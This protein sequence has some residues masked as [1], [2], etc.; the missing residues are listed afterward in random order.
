MLGHSAHHALQ[1]SVAAIGAPPARVHDLRHTFA[2][3]QLLVGTPM[4]EVSRMLGHVSVAFTLQVYAHIVP[5][6]QSRA[7]EAAANIIEE[8]MRLAEL[9]GVANA[10]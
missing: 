2:S 3:D 4:S 9:Q 10:K 8:A 6:V 7:A 5:E 1:R